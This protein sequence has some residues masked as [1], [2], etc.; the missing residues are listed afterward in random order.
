MNFRSI[1]ILIFIWLC[2]VCEIITV[3]EGTNISRGFLVYRT[4]SATRQSCNCS[5]AFSCSC[6]Q[7]VTILY[8][9]KQ[10]DLCVNFTYQRNGLN[11]DVALGSDIIN[12]RTVTSFKAFQFCV[13]VPGCFFST[14]C[15]NILELNKFPRSITACLRLDIYAKKQ[16]WQINYDCISISMELPMMSPNNTMRM[17]DMSLEETSIAVSTQSSMTESMAKML[18]SEIPI[19]QTSEMNSADISGKPKEVEDITEIFEIYEKSTPIK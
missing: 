1:G 3:N 19:I 10:K 11:V 14:A 17:T 4:I 13:Y 12:T 9:Q 7:S 16:L 8:T 6:C 2:L 5:M 18:S 15:I